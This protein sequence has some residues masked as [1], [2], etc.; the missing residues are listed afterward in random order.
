MLLY[1]LN[2]LSTKELATE[3]AAINCDKR[4]I[5]IMKEKLSRYTIK[6]TNLPGYLGL[7]IKET[8]LSCGAE[9]ALPAQTIKDPNKN[10]NFILLSN[11]NQLKIIAKKLASQAF[12][13][14]VQL[15]PLLLQITKEQPIK[16]PQIMGILN[17][18]PDSFSDGGKYNET[19]CALLHAKELI[20]AGANIIDIGGESTRPGAPEISVK[21]ELSRT[22]PIIKELRKKYPKTILSI[23][24]TKSK[25]AQAAAECGV[26]IIND[27]SGLTRDPK[28]A[29][30][31]ARY[32]CQLVL[33]HRSAR[34]NVMQKKTTYNDILQ[35]I[36]LF[37]DNAAK[38]AQKAGVKKEQI[39]IDPG[40]GFGK[41]AAQN[42]YLLKQLSAFK[43]LGYL[44]LLG[45]SRKSVIGTL[46]HN[47]PAERLAGTIAT[48]LAALIGKG[49]Y[50][51]VHDVKENSDALKVFAAI[52]GA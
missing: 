33:V 12:R 8:A 51:R 37:L 7:I 21:E 18:T 19:S 52:Y 41:T 28:I 27:V 24:T 30:I 44:V 34:S 10:Y 50:L 49:D 32:N 26:K 4:G 16:T 43:S 6:L 45:A 38:K 29:N 17:T 39:I 48:S 15:S 22:I 35:E 25:V 23:D 2:I 3:L 13:S 14:L 11:K 46:L 1:Q 5:N 9:C 40:I 31:A 42:L 47:Q 20:L 36:L